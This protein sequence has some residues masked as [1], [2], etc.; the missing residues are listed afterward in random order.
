VPTSRNPAAV[1]ISGPPIAF[2]LI[3]EERA[4][5]DMLNDSS[6]T[7]KKSVGAGLASSART[8]FLTEQPFAQ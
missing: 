8:N 6:T 7:K 2:T 4:V 3:M 5:I 1:D